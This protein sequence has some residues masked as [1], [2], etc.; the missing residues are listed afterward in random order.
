[1]RRCMLVLLCCVTSCA[2]TTTTTPPTPAPT[3]APTA[4]SV[5]SPPA[6]TAAEA[7]SEPRVA[8]DTTADFE[9]LLA[10]QPEDLGDGWVAF[11]ADPKSGQLRAVWYPDD[12][13]AVQRDIDATH[14]DIEWC[15]RDL[16]SWS[17]R[18]GEEY[19]VFHIVCMSGEDNI[20]TESTG[21]VF[22]TPL[23]D[24]AAKL[25][26]D[27]SGRVSYENGNQVTGCT[28]GDNGEL[29]VRNGEL[30]LVTEVWSERMDGYEEEAADLGPCEPPD[31]EPERQ[32]LKAAGK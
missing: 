18:V 23:A 4:P 20:T 26:P 21:Y 15:D 13:E 2:T 10:A 11:G 31:L 8:P 27:W 14:E 12:A 6:Q 19:V 9:G 7:V 30:W 32:L 17:T 28:D 29:E 24:T 22:R 25:T 16:S 1:M 5:E 3:P